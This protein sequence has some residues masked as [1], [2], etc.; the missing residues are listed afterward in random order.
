MGEEMGNTLSSALANK[1]L[2]ELGLTNLM[3]PVPCD[4]YTGIFADTVNGWNSKGINTCR[5]KI[6]KIFC[7]CFNFSLF[8]FND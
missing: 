1:L 3:N 4:R 7:K 5:T 8:I 6:T 2:D